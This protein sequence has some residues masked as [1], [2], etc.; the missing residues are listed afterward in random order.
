[1]R[2]LIAHC[3]FGLV[4]LHRQTG[5]QEQAVEHLTTAASMY[6]EMGMNFWL[7]KAKEALPGV[8]R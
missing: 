7:E 6:C 5:Q 2:P 3:H 1:M 8:R 4:Q